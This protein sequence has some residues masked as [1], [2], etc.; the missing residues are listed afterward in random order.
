MEINPFALCTQTELLS[1]LRVPADQRHGFVKFERRL[2][3]V[4]AKSTVTLGEDTFHVK[5]LK[6]EG[7]FAKVFSAIREGTDMDC[8]IAGIDAVLKVKVFLIHG[9]LSFFV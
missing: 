8:T 7:G 2:P 1:K 6:G 5:A 9:L 3:S 4:S